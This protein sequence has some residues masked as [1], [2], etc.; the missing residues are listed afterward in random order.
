MISVEVREGDRPINGCEDLYL[1]LLLTDTGNMSRAKERGKK[2]IKKKEKR[3]RPPRPCWVVVLRFSTPWLAQLGVG[4]EELVIPR[5]LQ[6]SGI[7]SKHCGTRTHLSFLFLCLVI[8][9]RRGSG[10]EMGVLSRTLSWVDAR[11]RIG[12]ELEEQ[13]PSLR[14]R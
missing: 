11:V 3:Y 5:F 12:A 10:S 1:I 2:N 13:E 6:Q 8:K 14:V 4:V 7:L 9:P